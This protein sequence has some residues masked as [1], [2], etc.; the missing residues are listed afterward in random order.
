MAELLVVEV[1][2]AGTM[3]LTLLGLTM[4]YLG[5]LTQLCSAFVAEED[6]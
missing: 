3:W 5:S 2:E 6:L 1:F 4:F